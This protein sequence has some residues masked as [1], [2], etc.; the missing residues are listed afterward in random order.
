MKRFEERLLD[1]LRR[2][3]AE[4]PRTEFAAREHRVESTERS[5]E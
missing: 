1:E 3:V 2:M 4:H 5:K